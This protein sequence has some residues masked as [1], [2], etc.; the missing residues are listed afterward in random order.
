MINI[1]LEE[2]IPKAQNDFYN[3]C[4]QDKSALGYM[5]LSN[6]KNWIQEL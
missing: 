6:F 1:Y 4:D 2:I 5:V 3:N